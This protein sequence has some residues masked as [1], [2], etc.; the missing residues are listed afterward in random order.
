MPSVI[1]TEAD[2][3]SVLNVSGVA[4]L[5]TLVLGATAVAGE[6]RHHTIATTFLL[7]PA[8]SRVVIAKVVAYTVAGALFG[9]VVEAAAVVVAVGWLA[10]TGSAI[11]FGSTVV[12]GLALTP[13]AT[14]LAA[15]FGVGISAAVPNQL[16]AVLVAFG[17]VMIAEQLLGGLVPSVARWLPFTGAGTAITGQ[18]PEIGAM[19]GVV[20]FSVYLVAIVVVG[21]QVTRSRDVA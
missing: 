3:R 8:R 16:G 10:A 9:L 19:A 18:H 1:E 12:A 14:G 4:V 21:I 13:V 15:G 7:T 5:F 17:W 6:H 11:P 20:L 2:L